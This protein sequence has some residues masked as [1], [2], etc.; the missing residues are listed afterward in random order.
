MMSYY[1]H[2]LLR[3]GGSVYFKVTKLTNKARD[4][5]EH[6]INKN[7]D[8]TFFRFHDFGAFYWWLICNDFNLNLINPLI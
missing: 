1:L 7:K 3:H 4:T 5:K 8:N 6:Y 2:L